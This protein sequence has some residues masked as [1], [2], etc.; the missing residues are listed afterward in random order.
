MGLILFISAC[1][2]PTTSET[3]NAAKATKEEITVEIATINNTTEPSAEDDPTSED[4]FPSQT[5][6]MQKRK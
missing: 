3:R 1:V 4:Y 5:E 2:P 6:L